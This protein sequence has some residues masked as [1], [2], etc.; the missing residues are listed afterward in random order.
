MLA[1]R[2]GRIERRAV[3]GAASLVL[4]CAG[5]SLGAPTAAQA[6][7]APAPATA[8][9]AAVPSP[10]ASAPEASAAAAAANVDGARFAPTPRRGDGS[11]EPLVI[12]ADRLSG[13]PDLETI[14]EGAV[15]LRQGPLSLKADRIEYQQSIDLVRAN[16]NVEIRRNG[17]VFSGPE[18]QLKVQ[19][20]EGYFL[21]PSYQFERT[22]AGGSADRFVFIDDSRSL[23]YGATYSSCP[24]PEPAWELKTDRVLL[25]TAADTGVAEGAVLRF[26]G[27]PILAAPSLS[28]PLSD[29]R[30]SGWLPPSINLDNKSGLSVAAPYYWNIAPNR[31][32]TFTPELFQRRGA[33]LGGEFRYLEPSYGGE[34]NLFALP[35]DR[36][37][38]RDR[39]SLDLNHRARWEGPYVGAVDY[40]LTALRVSDSDYWKDFAR[41]LPTITPR[42]LPTD[43]YARR[44]FDAAWG[45]TQIYARVQQWQVLQDRDLASTIVSPYQ[46][47]PQV[48]VSQRG[49]ARG[50]E[51]DWQ[52]EAN[53]FTNDDTVQVEGSRLHLLGS[54]ARP[55]SPIGANGWVVTPRVSL[56]AASYRTDTPLADGR[57]QASRVIPTVSLD[58]TWVLERDTYAF[59]RDMVQTLEPRL[60]YVNTPYRDQSGL[61]N[62]DS[63]PTDFNL[64]SI[65]ADNAFSGIDR[66][67][68][69]NQVTAGV[70]TRF[71]DRRTGAE[72]LRLGLA[73]R[74]LLRDQRITPDGEP[75]TQ[76]WS[77]LLLF[78]STSLVPRWWFDG[79][80][81]YNGEISR[82]VRSIVGARYSPGPFRTLSLNYRF[83]RDATEQIEVGWQWPLNGLAREHAA[84][85][86]A[87]DDLAADDPG[88][89]ARPPAS[90]GCSG[91]WYSVGRVNYSQ[92][93]S[94]ITDAIFGVEYDAGCWIGRVVAERLSTGRSEATTRLL[95]Q[96][97][98]VGLSR[99][100]SNPLRVLKDN[101]PGY[102]L[103]RDDAAA[104]T[105]AFANP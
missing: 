87:R 5:A 62:F 55:W 16:G 98:L 105:P 27:V 71:L 13:R 53:R 19:R 10:A 44:R 58:S 48:G 80:V 86:Q 22:A 37:A 8:A 79:A 56:N 99:L 1:A 102:R 31:D 57:T 23:A 40:G 52:T 83:N 29:A 2:G 91:A 90:A 60:L 47:E 9:S 11:A 93:D 89:L 24:A 28:F 43:A 76:R 75:V 36:V 42:L 70:T 73:Q 51:W 35:G 50:F 81:Q 46:R 65:Y 92:R 26:Y 88:R 18:V 39:W 67:S 6:Q 41:K 7:A 82:T 4:G 95:L 66:V 104:V 69:A 97:E 30:K 78:G 101:I 72:A 12:E 45:D 14:A 3:A 21:Q 17:N 100:G 34:L 68:D 63:A 74:L 25:D 64:T 96:L 61:P 49:A 38:D 54:L 32:A 33:G 15:V 59:G 77:D 84:A 94:R 85:A 20:F 103:L